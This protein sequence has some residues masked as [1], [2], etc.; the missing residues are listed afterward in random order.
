MRCYRPIPIG[1]VLVTTLSIVHSMPPDMT[2]TTTTR[3]TSPTTQ[4]SKNKPTVHKIVTKW[5]DDLSEIKQNWYE[6]GVS[7]PN[8]NPEISSYSPPISLNQLSTIS[9]LSGDFI[10]SINY[11]NLNPEITSYSPPVSL[12]PASVVDNFNYLSGPNPEVA[13]Y[14]PI[15]LN[16]ASSVFPFTSNDLLPVNSYST[17]SS[18]SASINPL[19]LFN[20]DMV[21]D[22]TIDAPGG[23]SPCPSIHISSSVLG[24][25]QGPGCS[26][27]NLVINSHFHQNQNPGNTRNPSVSTYD[28]PGDVAPVES[29]PLE[30]EGLALDGAGLSEPIAADS[31]LSDAAAADPGVADTGAAAP[32]AAAPQAA[33]PAAGGTGGTGGQGGDG[34]NG[35][36]IKLPDLKGLF[37][38]ISYICEK[39]GRLLSFLRNPYLYI[40]PMALFFAL[41]FFTILALF[42]WWI[43]L[44]LLYLGIKSNKQPK[45][46]VSF[47][48]H[49]HRPQHHPDGWFWNHQTKTWQNV[50][51]FP[52]RRNDGDDR[53]KDIVE[54]AI[55]KFKNKYADGTSIQSWKRRRRSTPTFGETIKKLTNQLMD[56]N[57]TTLDMVSDTRT[58]PIVKQ[59]QQDK[60][61]L[62]E[63]L[64]NSHAG[65][66]IPVD[67]DAIEIEDSTKKINFYK[68]ERPTTTNSGLSTWILLSG[69]G[70]STT[71]SP[72]TRKPIIKPNLEGSSKQNLTI[73]TTD[74]PTRIVKPIFRKR[75][76]STPKPM[77]TTTPTTTITT[78]TSR[79]TSEASKLT[80]IKA[81]VLSNAVYKKNATTTTKPT[82][83]TESSISSTTRGIKVQEKNTVS[84]KNSTSLPAE[85]KEGEVD[86]NN[87][88]DGKKKKTSTKRRK[89]KPKRR[90]PST[91]KSENTTTISKPVKSNKQNAI[92]TQL[93]NYLA[94]E[95]MP[96]VG[97]G[98]VGLMV[99]AG[100]ASY[101]LYPFGAARRTY[102]VDRKD[103]EGSYYYS[104]DYSGVFLRKKL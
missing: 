6:E 17:P 79:V 21:P 40:I 47:Y 41:G 70:S 64:E 56:V 75:T 25:Q 2:T 103:K 32:Q 72:I 82:S 1:L 102:E 74:K 18:S 104:D 12:S 52:H 19:N 23:G 27:L 90:K 35:G 77:T 94:R 78:T 58:P 49:I 71:K 26:D 86:L 99:T 55:Q 80:K 20:L 33:A 88:I 66:A 53:R 67:E 63:E 68:I 29:V 37:E 9:S 59:Q 69:Q 38:L 39:L 101:F 84:I 31:V 24:R 95:I 4:K 46:T 87:N 7:Y 5:S 97:V 42:P 89:N 85:A 92:S 62:K 50:L 15:S 44:L 11:P 73:I 34:D 81:S 96:T 30:E 98:L 83:T 51:D 36:G 65:V 76:P 28:S 13:S 100:L 93:Y 22:R 16:D 91:D 57:A 54:E 61:K 43:P 10:D 45:E 14:S 3:L 48:K 60:M 8:P